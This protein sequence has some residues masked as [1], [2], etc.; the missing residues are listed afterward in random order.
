MD[1]KHGKDGEN[2]CAKV[3]VLII[4]LILIAIAPSLMA[5]TG[6]ESL[7]RCVSGDPGAPVKMEVFS[8]YQCPPCRKFFLDTIR[9]LVKDYA[10]KKKVCVIYY[11]FPL[12]IHGYARNAARYAE[13]ARRL[14]PDQWQRVSEALY[15]HL[16]ECKSDKKIEAVAAGVLSKDEMARV[17]NLLKD[18]SIDQTINDDIAEG[19]RRQIKGTPTFFISAKGKTK[20]IFGTISYP[21]LKDYIDQ[22]L[23]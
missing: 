10:Y 15:L 13:A 12:E 19:Y 6:E 14:G 17:L 8:C 20:R 3:R 2:M 7:K 9:P 23:K 21:V 22:L 11:E 1:L 16:E 5:Q 18:P 4:V